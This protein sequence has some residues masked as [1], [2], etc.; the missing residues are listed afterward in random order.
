MRRVSV[1]LSFRLNTRK[2]ASPLSHKLDIG[3][4]LCVRMWLDPNDTAVSRRGGHYRNRI[5]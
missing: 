2:V 5:L 1:A 4:L 3:A